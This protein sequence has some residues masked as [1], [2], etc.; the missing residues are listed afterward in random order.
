MAPALKC[1]S[2]LALDLSPGHSQGV[3]RNLGCG[4]CR[5]IWDVLPLW[6]ISEDPLPAEVLALLCKSCHSSQGNEV[7]GSGEMGDGAG[8]IGEKERN[9]K[10]N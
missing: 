4:E 3:Q 9:G 7:A 6:L 1:H 10:E 5:G 8:E 2:L